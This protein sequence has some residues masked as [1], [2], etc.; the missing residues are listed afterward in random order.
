MTIF[1]RYIVFQSHNEI[2][3]SFDNPLPFGPYFVHAKIAQGGM[4]DVLLATSSQT[5]LQ[6][7]FLAIKKLLPHLNSNKPF[8]NL[9]VHEAKIGVLLN[10]PSVA[11]VFDLGSY[12]SEFFLAMEYIH[13]KSLDHV[14]ELI[15]KGEAPPLG[16]E[17]STY[18]VIEILRALAF[19]HQLKDKK[20][21]ELNII[22]RDVTPGNILLSY[23]GDVKL[24]D[25]GIATAENRLQPGFTRAA[26]GKVS[27]ISPE[28]A[29]NDPTVK[30]SD[31]YSLGVVY[32]QLLTGQLP[33][34]GNSSND[35]FKKVVDGDL[36][37]FKAASSELPKNLRALLQRCLDRLPRGRPQ[38]APEMF[39]AIQEIFQNEFKIDF[40]NRASKLY[41]KKKLSEHLMASFKK[42]ITE[43]LEII[44]R[45]LK[46][47]PASK[48]ANPVVPIKS[49]Q[50]E[51][52]TVFEADLTDEATRNYPQ[53][54]SDR[55]E[56]LAKLASNSNEPKS[57]ANEFEKFCKEQTQAAISPEIPDDSKRISIEQKLKISKLDRDQ[58]ETLK[59]QRPELEIVSNSDLVAF[60]T[61]TFSGKK[62]IVLNEVSDKATKI[63]P[64]FVQ[65]EKTK[66]AAIL[67]SSVPKWNFVEWAR[68]ARQDCFDKIDL[69]KPWIVKIRVPSLVLT[70]SLIFVTFGYVFR[71]EIFRSDEW[72]GNW[73]KNQNI[74]LQFLGEVSQE[75]QGL[76]AAAMKDPELTPNLHELEE[77]FQRE[78]KR[79][80]NSPQK[81]LH[82]E[83]NNYPAA[84]FDGLTKQP[85]ISELL[86][87]DLLFSFFQ[88]RGVNAK[89]KSD[90]TIYI[91]FFPFNPNA[92]EVNSFPEEFLGKH[93][94]RQGVIFAPSHPSQRLRILLSLARE[95]AKI[96]GAT[97]KQDPITHM[98]LFPTG[99]ANPSENPLYPQPKAELM[100]KDIPLS[101][102][103]KKSA[104]G[105]NEVI[106]GAQTAYELGWINQGSRDR[107]LK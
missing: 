84:L 12:Q 35:I 43:E 75:Q 57:T 55:K 73:R 25:F 44:K 15:A 20:D 92:T 96:Y 74:F 45:A 38:T 10:H 101:A 106:I 24:A 87:S 86:S 21:R 59:E 81:I 65:A 17:L 79:Y 97:D 9:L 89:A 80:T 26:L 48:I 102:V 88:E 68:Q 62:T 4:A 98:P 56:L 72:K 76:L 31:I 46:Y 77:F 32:F 40:T 37:D 50:G 27:Y 54:E 3:E 71:E 22:H 16:P 51:D 82:F 39:S 2:V 107:L 60:E 28:Q 47:S 58:K 104:A 29:V 61:E 49:E 103:Q 91:Y 100:A 6:G 23:I 36:T 30:A 33:F 42:E 93:H 34:K 78:F 5:E 85:N 64:P 66:P 99:Y 1:I 83:I 94:S 90:A 63:A 41:F 95:I 11:T 70:L 18:V 13:G 67:K 69:I 52:A 105:F 8:V 19:A 14:I 53:S 7:Q